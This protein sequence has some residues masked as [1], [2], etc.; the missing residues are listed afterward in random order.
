MKYLI[1]GDANSMHIFNYVKTVLEGY[2][3]EIHLLT[4]STER[5][6][7]SYRRYYREHLSLIHI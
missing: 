7:E 2:P 5:V 1:I 3:F 6:K 4:L